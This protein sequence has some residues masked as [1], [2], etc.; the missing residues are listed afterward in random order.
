MELLHEVK[1][2]A[3]RWFAIA[4][5]ELIIILGM[6]AGIMWYMTLPTEEVTS[7]EQESTQ[8]DV[9]NSSLSQRI[10]GN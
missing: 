9:T 6:V 10:G 2:S 7:Y 4:I 1:L 5:I 8:T 3:K